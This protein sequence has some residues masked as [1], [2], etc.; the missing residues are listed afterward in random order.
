MAWWASS[1]AEIGSFRAAA[2]AE[3]VGDGRGIHRSTL[4]RA[5]RDRGRVERNPKRRIALGIRE[6]AFFQA[7]LSGR[8]LGTTSLYHFAV[9]PGRSR[10]L[11]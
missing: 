10:S 1:T 2:P 11:E 3:N 7:D 8:F 9:A 5:G 6:L 4:L